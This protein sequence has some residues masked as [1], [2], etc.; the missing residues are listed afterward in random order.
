M[1][2]HVLVVDP[3]REEC[4]QLQS[5]LETAGYRVSTAEAGDRA[6]RA[7]EQA[8][9]DVVLLDVVTTR[10]DGFA[11]CR[12]L[13]Q[14]P[15]GPQ[16]AI[17][18]LTPGQDSASQDR[19][20]EAGADDCLVRPLDNAELLLKLR[21]VLRFKHLSA[22]QAAEHERTRSER[23]ALMRAQHLRE[24][25]IAL[26]VHDMKNPLAG[27]L[28]NA[29]YMV[30]SRGLTADQKDCAQ[31]IL[32]ASRRLHR[33]V[34]SLLD[35]NLHEHGE[36]TPALGPVDLAEVVRKSV[37]HSAASMVDKRLHCTISGDE[38]PLPM[39]ADRDMLMRLLGNLL[40]NAARSSPHGADICIELG[41]RGETLDVR[42]VDRGPRLPSEYRAQIFENYVPGDEALRRA[43]KGRGLGLA[44]C[45]AIAL[46]HGGSI[47]VEEA[48]HGTQF[49]VQLPAAGRR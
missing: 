27:V 47:R 8:P 46:A 48:E 3:A 49:V 45:R 28:S 16:A 33:L 7:F 20:F 26:V 4:R 5:S 24:E 34:M 43:R 23:D 13:R 31:D 29:E 9:A 21:S 11:T 42:V 32:S 18:C 10:F 1:S 41:R 17:L 25:T 22:E 12:R 19:A 39:R 36:L 37:H 44:S 2:E 6:L 14:L 40:D 15:A 30:G 38:G 35:V